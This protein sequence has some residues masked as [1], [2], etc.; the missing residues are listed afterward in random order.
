MRQRSPGASALAERQV[1]QR[2]KPLAEL[3][4]EIRAA[5]RA[6]EL[7]AET[8]MTFTICRDAERSGP[9]MGG[10]RATALLA[11][12]RRTPSGRTACAT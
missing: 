2:F 9:G 11:W 12:E 1:K 6:G 4:P 5:W 3:V 10:L 8:A 7:G